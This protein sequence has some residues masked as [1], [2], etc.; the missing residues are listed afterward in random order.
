[1]TRLLAILALVLAAP[2]APALDQLNFGI[3]A[4]ESSSNLKK[5]FEALRADL[6]A[7]IGIPVQLFFAPDYTG[8]IE[9]M[10]FDKVQLGWFGNNS[11]IDAVDRASGEVF[12]QVVDKDG[13]PGY[14]SL[15]IVHNDSPLKSLEDLLAQRSTISF[16]MGDPQSTSGTLVPGYYAF[17]KNGVNPAKDFK[18]CRS[19]NHEANGLA[20]ANKLV[21]ASTFN[22]E[23]MFR[24]EQNNP[25]AAKKLRPIW[26]SPLIAN[27]PLVI[28]TTV[29]P[30]LKK[31]V[32]D[33]FIAYG[34]TP[35]QK[36]KIAPLKWSGF[37]ASSN[38]QLN[39]YRLMR[40]LKEKAK[41]ENDAKMSAEDKAAK[42]AELNK[43]QAELE[44][45]VAGAKPGA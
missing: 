41:V 24:L 42:L 11:G 20:V 13:N 16:S 10:R 43:A 18:A 23:A 28:R 6:A 34:S 30:A 33:F 1:M 2:L 26:K 17:G 39:P 15:I 37:K 21:D 32:I 9:G 29:E 8:V 31:K 3:I 14:W 35:E 7:T 44:A 45:K 36:A 19:A 38:D 4:T 5:D 27:D 40:L 22:T 12:C 25:E